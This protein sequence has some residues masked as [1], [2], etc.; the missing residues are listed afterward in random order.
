M[1]FL[2]ELRRLWVD[3]FYFIVFLDRLIESI[4]RK[5]DV[6]LEQIGFHIVFLH[7]NQFVKYCDSLLIALNLMQGN[8]LVVHN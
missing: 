5:V 4:K 6:T 3:F 1:Q 7:L 2:S 8:C